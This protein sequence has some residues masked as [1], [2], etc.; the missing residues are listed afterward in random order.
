MGSVVVPRTGLVLAA[1]LQHFSGK[2]WAASTQVSLPQGDQRILLE[3]RGTRRLS[4]QS[5]LD[6]RVSRTFGSTQSRVE[7]LLDVLNVLNDTA[8]EA[9]AT[10]NLFSPNFGRPT[11]FMDPRR[12]MVSVRLNLDR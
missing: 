11:L 9:V 10:D 7:L 5:L 3:P 4:S 12:A 6:L 8:E 1:N 2:P